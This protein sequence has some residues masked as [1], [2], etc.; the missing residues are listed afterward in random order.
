MLFVGSCCEA[1]T[2]GKITHSVCAC[3]CVNQHMSLKWKENKRRNKDLIKEYK[4][5]RQRT[6]DV[7]EYKM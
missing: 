5:V 4:I 3:V 7:N 6:T 2:D 1:N